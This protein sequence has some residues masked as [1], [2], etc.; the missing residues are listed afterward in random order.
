MREYVYCGK[1][2]HPL[3]SSTSHS[4]SINESCNKQDHSYSFWIAPDES[5][6]GETL[7]YVKNNSVKFWIRH[8]YFND[9]R[10]NTF[11][12]YY[13]D[14]LSSPFQRNFNFYCLDF[15]D[16]NLEQTVESLLVVS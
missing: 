16:P 7:M 8:W 5:S 13:H 6:S 10:I 4:F 12:F 9:G 2:E 14:S 15:N 11:L 1:C 3:T